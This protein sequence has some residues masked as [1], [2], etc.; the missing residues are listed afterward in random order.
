[1]QV[2]MLIR[3]HAMYQRSRTMLIFLTVVLLTAT[4]ASAVMM[5]IANIGVSGVEN[6]FSGIPQCGIYTSTDDV[7]LHDETLIPTTVWEILALF[8]AAWIVIKHFCELRQSPTGSTIRDGFTV[9]TRSH[10]LYFIVFAAV[11]F[12]NIVPLFTNIQYSSSVGAAVYFGIL[13]VVTVLQMFVLGP[14]LI[15][16]VRQYH[17]KLVTDSDEGT[18]MTTIAF[19]EGGHVSTGGD[20]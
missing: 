9:L 1:M 15:L 19:Q 8:L 17:A 20:V 11:S 16:S 7:R 5:A 4:I 14:R 3:I 13:D 18:G 6:V 2:I 12:F 10:I